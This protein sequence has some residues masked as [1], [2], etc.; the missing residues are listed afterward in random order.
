MV[1]VII[2]DNVKSI[3]NEAFAFCNCLK[4]VYIGSGLAVL[5]GLPFF[6]CDNL[7]SFA[8][9]EKNP[10]Y[11]G[12]DGI[13]YNKVSD[14][15]EIIPP[16]VKIPNRMLTERDGVL[17]Y[18]DRIEK[19]PESK[20]DSVYTIPEDIYGSEQIAFE[21]CKYL[22]EIIIPKSWKKIPSYEFSSCTS[23]ERITVPEGIYIINNSAFESCYHLKKVALPSTLTYI[24]NSAFAACWDLKEIN[25]PDRLAEIGPNAFEEC[26]SIETIRIPGSVKEISESSF[27]GCENLKTV[28]IENGVTTIGDNAF[29]ECRS[30]QEIYIPDSVTEIGD[31]AFQECKALHTVRLPNNVELGTAVFKWCYTLA[32]IQ[33]QDKQH[34]LLKADMFD[35]GF[36][37]DWDDDEGIPF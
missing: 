13:L 34:L 18:K 28:I 29:K 5:H 27:K 7:A 20:P 8:V 22:K 31:N 30:L 10:K 3:D 19:Y 12:E 33:T 11:S 23:L 24:Q 1:K 37:I 15:L 35:D 16:K 14:F 25:L 36:D 32:N 2:P 6:E 26:H 4:E 9:S 21:H 17:C